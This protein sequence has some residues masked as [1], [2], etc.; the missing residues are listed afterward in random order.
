MTIFITAGGTGGHIFPGY[1]LYGELVNRGHQVLFVG[2][3]ADYKKFDCLERLG[4]RFIGLPVQQYYRKKVWRNVTSVVRFFSSVR[5]AR[6]LIRAI[7]P[8]VC[9]GMGGFASAPMLFACCQHG[10][11]YCIAEQNAWP[12]RA[13]KY[14][15]RKASAVFLNFRQA[16]EIFPASARTRTHITGNPVRPDF[17]KVSQAEARK[18]MGIPVPGF[19]LGVMGGSQGARAINNAILDIASRNKK[20]AILWSCGRNNYDELARSVSGRSNIHLHPFVDD[21]AAF[22]SASSLVIS[23]AGATSLA[24]LAACQTPS[25]LVPYP[26]ASD[27][28][29]RRNAR[30]W[31]EAGAAVVITEGLDFTEILEN[32]LDTLVQD[33]EQ[34]AKMCNAAASLHDPQTLVHMADLVEEAVADSD[35]RGK[36]QKRKGKK[37]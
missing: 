22:L 2:A 13:N 14:F 9:V 20:L 19:V 36:K 21:M 34:L 15:A 25:I 12:G 11:P 28:H 37:R 23:R 31:E 17:G 30:A 3:A 35:A 32:A 33:R 29:Q 8:D 10:I 7:R 1:A 16:I 5:K 27:D 6:A 26:Y 24:E 18:R 4:H